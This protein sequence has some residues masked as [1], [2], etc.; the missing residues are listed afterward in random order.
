MALGGVEAPQQARPQVK[1]RL[2]LMRM[3]TQQMVV[4]RMRTQHQATAPLLQ[5]SQMW[6]TRHATLSFKTLPACRRD[7][8]ARCDGRTCCIVS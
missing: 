1:T 6:L 3:L 7:R 5:R 4:R 8:V 2:L